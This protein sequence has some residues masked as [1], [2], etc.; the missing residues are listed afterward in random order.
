MADLVWMPEQHKWLKRRD[1]S[2]LASTKADQKEL[3]KIY[4]AMSVV[5]REAALRE[6]R[7]DRPL[8]P[9]TAK[10]RYPTV[11]DIELI[12]YPNTLEPFVAQ[13][14]F[15]GKSGSHLVIDQ[16][17]QRDVAQSWQVV[18]ERRRIQ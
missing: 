1:R 4:R 8:S 9:L 12:D 14:T 3:H 15:G 6:P 7:P 2:A 5:S 13:L 11:P 16:Y 17:W 10:W 18:V